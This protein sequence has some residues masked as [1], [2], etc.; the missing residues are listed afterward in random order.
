[1]FIKKLNKDRLN[2][3]IEQVEILLNKQKKKKKK[4]ITIF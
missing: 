2:E 1:M 4:E 3:G